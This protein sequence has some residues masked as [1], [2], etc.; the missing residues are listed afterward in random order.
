MNSSFLIFQRK[1]DNMAYGTS[2]DEKL[3]KQFTKACKLSGS[4]D[5]TIMNKKC[6]RNIRK[7]F[8]EEISEFDGLN[9]RACEE[10][11]FKRLMNPK[12]GTIIVDGAH[13]EAYLTE[14]AHE[15]TK[16]KKDDSK[17]MRSDPRV[18]ITKDLLE[19][20][21]R[22]TKVYVTGK[23]EYVDAK[24]IDEPTRTAYNKN[25]QFVKPEFP[26]GVRQ[27]YDIRKRKPIVIAKRDYGNLS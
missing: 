4:D 11:V 3:V 6:S 20:I 12:T 14:M 8:W 19:K 22:E 9:L 7:F 26:K 25:Y 17:M 10:E 18:T 15:I 21:V 2:A 1:S 13:V 23:V 27:I 5:K 24:D 16:R